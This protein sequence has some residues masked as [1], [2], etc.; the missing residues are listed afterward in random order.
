M[1]QLYS[2]LEGTLEHYDNVR[3]SAECTNMTAM[4]MCGE[5]LFV[6]YVLSFPIFI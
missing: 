3:E 6:A 4:G 5:Q 1:R 2:A